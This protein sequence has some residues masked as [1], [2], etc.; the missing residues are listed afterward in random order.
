MGAEASYLRVVDLVEKSGRLASRAARAR[1]G[2]PRDHLLRRQALR[3]GRRQVR[4][5]DRARAPR[6]GTLHGG[7][8]PVPRKVR[9]LARPAGPA[10]D[11][12]R[13]RRY[14]LRAIERS[15][16]AAACGTDRHS[17]P[18]G[19]GSPA[20]G[21]MIRRA[22]RCAT[23]SD[24]R[25]REG[26]GRR[27]THRPAD[28]AR[29]LRSTSIARPLV[30][31]GRVAGR[32]EAVAVPRHDAAGACRRVAEHVASEGQSSLNRA[33]AIAGAQAPPSPGA[34]RRRAYAARRLVPVARQ[35]RAGA[36]VELRTRVAGRWRLDPG[37]KPVTDLLF[38]RPVQLA[39]VPPGSWDRYAGRP[40]DEASCA[41]AE[42]D[43]TVTARGH[44][45][46]PKVLSDA[47]NRR[48]VEAL[49]A[50]QVAIYRPRLE[51]ARSCRHT[52]ASRSSNRSTSW[53]RRNRKRRRR[54]AQV[55]PRPKACASTAGAHF[56]GARS[57]RHR[58]QQATH[59]RLL[60]ELGGQPGGRVAH[61]E[62]H[63]RSS[64]RPIRRTSMLVFFAAP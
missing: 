10:D 6:A 44:V 42:I 53:S 2:R 24:H 57:R 4:A 28:G 25:G 50:A 21:R 61:R 45:A 49:R 52:P 37:R 23:P 55:E 41:E 62:L 1:A 16:G 33:V 36:T 40:P 30:R 18:S 8:D 22:R 11:A 20:S 27:G 38:G 58:W 31:E 51:K 34:G 59:H 12:V 13:A 15:Y 19:A 63:R 5:G 43:F 3:P 17:S 32:T 14:I 39:Y 64:A 60:A 46:D 56:D 35:A 54:V 48:G 47:G 29:G 26:R 7:T 9:R